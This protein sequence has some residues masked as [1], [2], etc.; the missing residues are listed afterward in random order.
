MTTSSIHLIDTLLQRLPPTYLSGPVFEL[1][2]G[3]INIWII[4]V[5]P[6]FFNRPGKGLLFELARL[7][8]PS[9]LFGKSITR[10]FFRNDLHVAV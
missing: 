2:S 8:A 4:M 10:D 9:I 3:L 7:G 5:I 6:C 1:H